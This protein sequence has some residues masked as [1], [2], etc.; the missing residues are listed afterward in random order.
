MF[1]PQRRTERTIAGQLYDVLLSGALNRELYE[2]GLAKDTFQGRF[3]QVALHGT[4]MMRALRERGDHGVSRALSDAIFAGFDHAYRETGVGDSS[5]SR[6]VR[7]LGEQFYG[8]ARGLD[9]ALDSDDQTVLQ[10]FATRNGLENDNGEKLIAYLRCANKR[11]SG[12]V[13]LLKAEWPKP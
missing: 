11:L 12:T 4:L 3:E 2:K 9:Q 5:I 13:D 1:S 8:L 6:K 7:K 10:A